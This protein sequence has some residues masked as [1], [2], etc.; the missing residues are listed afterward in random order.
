MPS[1]L[2]IAAFLAAGLAALAAPGEARATTVGQWLLDQGP[3]GAVIGAVADSSGNGFTGTG[4]PR[5]GA[6]TYSS[7]VPA[8]FGG[9]SALFSGNSMIDMAGTG[10]SALGFTGSFTIEAWIRETASVGS[11]YALIAGKWGWTGSNNAGYGLFISP[12]DKIL[13]GISTNGTDLI[14]PQAAA[15]IATNTWYHVAGVFDH[16]A[17]TLTLYVTQ[18][19]Q[20]TS[21][22]STSYT[23]TVFNNAIDFTIGGYPTQPPQGQS[24]AGYIDEVRVSNVALAQAALGLNGSIAPPVPE[25]ATLGLALAGLGV[26]V[27]GA[28]RRR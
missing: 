14:G 19:G 5:A 6:D 20:A 12:S 22:F 18:Q 13:F 16:A 26:A 11:N 24:V 25:P 23:G 17:N 28:R 9:T 7:T 4:T 2:Q 15:A 8:G 3:S 27:R 1:R 21:T 10:T